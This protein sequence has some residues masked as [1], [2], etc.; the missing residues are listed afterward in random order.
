MKARP[1]WLG[2]SPNEK[3]AEQA[4]RLTEARER[5]RSREL[6]TVLETVPVAVYIARDPDCLRVTGNSAAYQQ[7]GAPPGS[8]LSRG[9]SV[10]DR[11]N[12]RVLDNGIEVSSDL[13]PFQQSASTGRAIHNRSLTILL[14]DGGRKETIVN[15]APLFDEDGRPRGAVAASI[16]VTDLKQTEQALR[17]SETRFRMLH[18]RA[19]VGI[20]LV[21]ATNLHFVQTNP[22][23]CEIVGRTAAELERMSIHDVTHPED[24][25]VGI[26]QLPSLAAGQLLQTEVEK[27]YLRPDGSFRWGR[28]VTVPMF[29]QTEEDHLLFMALVEDITERNR[30]QDE[31]RQSEARFRMLYE[32]APIGIALVDYERSNFVQVNPAF[33]DLIGRSPKS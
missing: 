24:R 32:R 16:D 2:T 20:A 28:V 12:I 7:L 27:R 18:E 17:H 31:L 14:P 6:E 3:R 29:A 8:N 15:V 9:A 30:A 5:A 1:A 26:S 19:P 25:D 10:E 33:C 4:L 11:P 21:D 23:F 22:R 13:L